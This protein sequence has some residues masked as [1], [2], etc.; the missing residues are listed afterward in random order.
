MKKVTD[1]MKREFKKLHE[2]GFTMSDIAKFFD[3]ST[4]TVQYHLNPKTKKKAL[5]RSKRWH[6]EHPEIHNEVNRKWRENN[7]LK[8]R[9]SVVLSS[10]KIY[11]RRGVINE[12]DVLKILKEVKANKSG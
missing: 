9:R 8:F 4:S 1:G 7:P 6:K 5:E 11:L 12:E 10:I 2:A 3:L